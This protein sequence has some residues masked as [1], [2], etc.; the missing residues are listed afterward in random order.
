MAE[1]DPSTLASECVYNFGLLMMSR[2][3]NLRSFA[4]AA[5]WRVLATLTTILLVY[6]ATGKL[7]LAL[8][9]GS[10]EVVAK[11]ALYYIHERLWQHFVFGL[12]D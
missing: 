3:T 7:T 8:S 9:V 6:F 12:K 1:R 5:S 10:L 2:E 4:K 11:L